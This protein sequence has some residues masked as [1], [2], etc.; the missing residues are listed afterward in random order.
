MVGAEDKVSVAEDDVVN[1]LRRDA[2]TG[3]LL[4]SWLHSALCGA[5]SKHL[6]VARSQHSI[7][8]RYITSRG[9]N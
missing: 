3:A 8:N 5:G 4:P 9:V 7:S 6:H 1:V 2:H